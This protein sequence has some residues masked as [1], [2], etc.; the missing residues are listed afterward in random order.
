MNKVD[1]GAVVEQAK[2]EM[3]NRLS[4]TLLSLAGSGD[5]SALAG[6]AAATGG[7][8]ASAA[9]ANAPADYEPVWIETP[10]CTACDE[11][12][13]INPKIFAYNDD[14]LAI[15]LNPQAGSYKDIVRAAEKC[16]AGCLHPGTPWNMSE[17]D[18]DKLIK[19]AEK[20]Q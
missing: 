1:V 4:A 18:V 15:V 12:I 16:T 6:A 8:A 20:Y 13:G 17:K 19:R 9:G 11:C 2:V 5:V 3:A 14:K 10:E 7:A